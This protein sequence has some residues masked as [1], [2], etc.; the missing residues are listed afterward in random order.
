[1]KILDI[2]GDQFFLAIAGTLGILCIILW[3]SMIAKIMAWYVIILSIFAAY[4]GWLPQIRGDAPADAVA[5]DLDA[6]T[7]EKL[8]EMG[9]MIIFGTNDPEGVLAGG[10]IQPERDSARSVINFS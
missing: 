7:P 5:I 3:R 1:M 9:K 4:T 10:G 8:A 6:A 2:V